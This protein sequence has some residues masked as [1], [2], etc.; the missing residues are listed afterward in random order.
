MRK[1]ARLIRLVV[2]SAFVFALAVS[3]QAATAP[4][5]SELYAGWLLSWLGAIHDGLS[6]EAN[7]SPILSV[8]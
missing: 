4:Q 5:E 2:A 8:G 1:S 6:R 3:T 7:C